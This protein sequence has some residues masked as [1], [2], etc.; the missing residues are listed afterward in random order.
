MARFML[1]PSATSLCSLSALRADVALRPDKPGHDERRRKSMTP[2]PSPHARSRTA[3][4][5]SR[6]TGISAS[7]PSAIDGLPKMQ[8]VEIAFAGRS[9]VGKSSLINALTVAQGAGAH[10]AYAGPHA[11]TD[12]LLRR[13]QASLTIVDMP[14]YGYAEAPKKKVEAWTDLIH[15]FLRGRANLARV[16]VLIDAR[17]G[18]KPVDRAGVRRARRGGGELRDRADQSRSGESGRAREARSRKPA[19][20][21]RNAP[22]RFPI[23]LATSSR[24]GTGVPELR[25]AI[26]RLVSE[27]GDDAAPLSHLPDLMGAAGVALAAASAHYASGVGLGFGRLYAAVPCQ[28]RDRA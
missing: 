28:R 13:E 16:Y 2:I 5:S 14:G 12:L 9:N 23:V 15:A 20:R 1:G 26:S 8:G 6:A 11:G 24:A 19:P 4:C 25:A 17:H 3:A 10:L 22:L 18:L 7:R 27:R 21:S